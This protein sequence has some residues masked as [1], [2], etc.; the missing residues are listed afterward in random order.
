MGS[1]TTTT[2]SIAWMMIVSTILS[3]FFGSFCQMC[4]FSVCRC[5]DL[6]CHCNGQIRNGMNS[7]SF[8]T[9]IYCQ[10]VLCVAVCVSV[11]SVCVCQCLHSSVSLFVQQI[12]KKQNSKMVWTKRDEKM[13]KVQRICAGY[14]NPLRM[15]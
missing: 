15:Q 2:A 11:T 7:K 4:I 10:I 13:E 8:S 3:A 14:L 1:V 9:M 5:V 12:K 6:L